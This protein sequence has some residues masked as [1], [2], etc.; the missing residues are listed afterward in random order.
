[1]IRFVGVSCAA[2][3]SQEEHQGEV[4]SDGTPM[5]STEAPLGAQLYELAEKR[6]VSALQN[7]LSQRPPPPLAY[8][9]PET[10]L[11]ALEAC[12]LL[13]AAD[14]SSSAAPLSKAD[15][16]EAAASCAECAFLLLNAALNK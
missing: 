13:A 15:R 8:R 4:D 10:G 6:S 1:M 3:R 5:S 2:L 11:T 14:T 16:L 7:L 12:L 9:H